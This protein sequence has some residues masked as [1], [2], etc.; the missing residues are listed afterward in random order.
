MAE[1]APAPLL[2]ASPKY[3]FMQNSRAV[4]Q[5]RDMIASTVFQHA[6]DFALLQYQTI[7]AQN[8]KG[9]DD[10]TLAG[11]KLR[12]AHEFLETLT[13]MAE[14]PRMPA[15]TIVEGLDHKA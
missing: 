15:P 9:P 3:R 1:T 8:T 4:S 13:M 10:A 14:T 2:N 7:L 5:H 12:G 6:T 11:L